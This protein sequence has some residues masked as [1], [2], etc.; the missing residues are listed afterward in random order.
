MHK[1]HRTRRSSGSRQLILKALP[2]SPPSVS[3]VISF[4]HLTVTFL[5]TCRN[6]ISWTSDFAIDFTR[7]QSLFTIFFKICACNICWLQLTRH[8][9]KIQNKNILLLSL[10]ESNYKTWHLSPLS[11]YESQLEN[12]RQQS[13]NMEQ[14]NYATQTLKDTKTTVR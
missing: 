8:A 12:L 6:L 1:R 9:V 10:N 3:L 14:T 13:S 4:L 5:R 7:R 2:A 11:R